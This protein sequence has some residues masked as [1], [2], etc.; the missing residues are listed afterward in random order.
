VVEKKLI[1]M[2]LEYVYDGDK[3]NAKTVLIVIE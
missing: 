1:E 3:E 2:G